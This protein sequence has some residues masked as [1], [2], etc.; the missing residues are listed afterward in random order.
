MIVK[1]EE[2]HL[3]DCLKS[4]RPFVEEIVIV[5][6][7]STDKTLEVAAKYA[8]IVET[9]TDCNYDDGQI[10]SFAEARQK[11]FD[12]ATQP[13]VMWI[14]A[15]DVMQGAE[16]LPKMIA[17]F[18][19]QRGDRA[20]YAMLPY[21]Y[22]HDDEGNCICLHYRERIVTPKEAFR[23]VNP[24]H[25]V[26]LSDPEILTASL[27]TEMI[28]VIHERQKIPRNT[29]PERNLRI[30]KD[31]CET[32]GDD[33]RQLYYLG[34]EYFNVGNLPDSMKTL[35]KYVE[36]SGWEDEK[37][38]ALIKL[39]EINRSLGNFDKSIEWGT[40]A[41]L[42]KESWGEC[43]FEI[44]KTYYF[45]A[46]TESDSG[47]KRRLY[48]KCANFS[49]IGLTLPP[50]KT[51]LFLNPQERDVEIHRYLNIALNAMGDVGSA[52]DSVNFA[53]S[54]KPK[55]EQLLGNKRLYEE[56]IAH[57]SIVENVQKLLDMGVV[58]QATLESTED[59]THGRLHAKSSDAAVN[60]G[61][62]VW[63]PYHRPKD[64]PRGV[65]QEDFPTAVITPHSQAWGIPDGGFVYD[66]LPLQTTDG[67]MQSM[68]CAIWK[69]YILHD[70]IL[71]AI[72]FLENAPYRVRHTDITETM[73]QRTR[74]MIAWTAEENSYDLGNSTIYGCDGKDYRNDE[75]VPIG[76]ELDG[77]AGMR[78]TW[79]TD[80]MKK[81]SSLLDFG[82]IDGEMTNRWGQEGFEVTGLDISTNSVRIANESAERN[83]TGARHIRTFFKDAHLHLNGKK[84][85]YVTCAD[86]YEHLVNGGV[87]DL[88]VPMRQHVKDTGKMLLV[89]PHGAWFRG[90]FSNNAH[91]WIWANTRGD[92]WL[93]PNDR[94]HI[95][96]PTVWSV[97]EEA[98]KAGWFV[99]NCT[100]IE[101]WF[102]DVPHQGN[103]CIEGL[104]NAP[105]GQFG[106]KL[107]IVFYIG[108]LAGEVWTP[109]TV[110]IKGIGGS[111]LAAI[112]MA[113]RLVSLGNKVRV[114]S[115][116]GQEGE[117]I[118]DGVEYRTY[119]KFHDLKCDVLV[120]SR[121]APALGREHNVE[122]RSRY[123]WV[124]DVIPYNL[125]P[126]LALRTDKI[127][128]L[129]EWHKSNIVRT[130]GFV[131]PE[132]VHVTRNGIDPKRFGWEFINGKWK[133]ALPHRDSHR[134][135]YSSSPDRGLECLLDVWPQIKE[136][137][138]D[139][140]LDIYYGFDNWERCA[141]GNPP[142]QTLI[143]N[144]KKKIAALKSSD[145][146]LNGR[147][148]QNTLANEFMK[149]GV[150]AYP[151]WFSETSCITAME[152]QAAGL[153]IVTSPIAALNETV[154]NRGVMITG[155]WL[156]EDY[157]VAF[158]AAVIEALN[159]NADDR[160]ISMEYA[161]KNFEWR[162]VAY[163][164]D[165]LFET[166]LDAFPKY[167]SP[168]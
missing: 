150:W 148:N 85:D 147:V 70:E 79:I 168:A 57:V 100:A 158:T 34:L 12:L 81:G 160:H 38:L 69:E 71:S 157:K 129:S 142:Q 130:H 63:K 95:I 72:K 91:P 87:E 106:P 98:R 152:A 50:T 112:N 133:Q 10:R 116:C 105:W 42:V 101:Q 52:L 67:Q 56:H 104:P 159:N 103:V 141:Q 65:T 7:G 118:Y 48:E 155:D 115:D 39:C 61:A 27:N 92:H 84:F 90:K 28:R 165:R 21:E 29:N 32:H 62:T 59:F 145:V 60:S 125:T 138:P 74:E 137:V 19:A 166:G 5:D 36:L 25:E 51:V 124:H 44:A 22:A 163:E 149:S 82:C 153:R 96:A 45:Q 8:D 68:V 26:L 77:S 123:L 97:A 114:Y 86:T 117:G 143:A 9:Y 132:Q 128:A 136:N 37:T 122:A 46:G 20:A 108:G 64:Y 80:R 107:D 135:V 121:W 120:V 111:E 83:K 54:K 140:S 13:W 144:I 161:K 131:D 139:A 58:T 17:D 23:W 33:P 55:D 14:D 66:D 11:S 119:N 167:R 24:V 31:Y 1:N 41:A 18:D 109:H 146:R 4:I 127:F 35:E 126:E 156:S 49:K 43:Y 30:L 93:T 40:K 3:E 76:Y 47:K 113:K 75:M 78:K 151:T 134:L 99:Q 164:W 154:G 89:T 16:H 94:G 110:D 6:T 88:L 73:L 53:L 102:Q 162:G 15:D 2:F